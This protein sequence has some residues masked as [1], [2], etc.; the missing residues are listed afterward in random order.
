[1][2]KNK[3]SSTQYASLL[4]DNSVDFIY[5]DGNHS[6]SSVMED[7]KIWSKKVKTNGIISGHDFNCPSVNRALYEYFNNPPISVY[8]DGSWFYYN[9]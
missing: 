9:K 4:E 5:I 6:Y 3:M 8:T 7:L 1:M 2:R